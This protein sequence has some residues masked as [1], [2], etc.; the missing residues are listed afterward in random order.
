MITFCS[1]EVDTLQA[2]LAVLANLSRHP[3]P[4]AKPNLLLLKNMLDN[5][6]HCADWLIGILIMAY[7]NPHKNWVV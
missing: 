4:T 5:S 7:Y 1:S 6:F 3:D 2:S